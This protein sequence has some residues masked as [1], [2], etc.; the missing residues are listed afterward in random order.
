M[1]HILQVFT[2]RREVT[3]ETN[4]VLLD[5]VLWRSAR[6]VNTLQFMTSPQSCELCACEP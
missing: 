5:P 1:L 3:W 4:Y 6:A 2:L